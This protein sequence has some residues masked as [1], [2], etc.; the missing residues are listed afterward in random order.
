MAANE[1]SQFLPSQQMA[2]KAGDIGKEQG[3]S[4]FAVAAVGKHD[5]TPKRDDTRFRRSERV[6]IIVLPPHLLCAL[7]LFPHHIIVQHPAGG[8]IQRFP[9][10]RRIATQTERL[11]FV[12]GAAGGR[13]RAASS[14]EMHFRP[15]SRVSSVFLNAFSPPPFPSPS[16]SPS[17]SRFPPA[18]T[19]RLGSQVCSA[20]SLS[21]SLFLR[22]SH[23]S[24]RPRRHQR[25]SR[26]R[27]HLSLS[28]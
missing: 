25:P 20:L 24:T 4:A 6:A 16:P 5:A 15:K 8:S 1:R 26:R 14:C 3:H 11:P 13:A 12:F 2:L 10:P 27:R 23:S 17:P 7:P 19:T 28:S 22:S 9:L 21:L 18:A